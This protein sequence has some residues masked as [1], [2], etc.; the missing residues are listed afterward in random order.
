M[1]KR[2]RGR[3]DSFLESAWQNNGGLEGIPYFPL[4]LL[5]WL[6]ALLCHLRFSLY[7]LG[8]LPQKKA[9]CPVVSVGNLTVGG[10]GKTPVTLYLAEQWQ[11]RGL[12]VGIVSRGY[13]RNKKEALVLVSAGHGPLESPADVGDEPY[14]MAR[15]LK[16]IPIVVAS[17][18]HSGCERITSDFKLDLILLDD[19]FQHLRLKRDLNILLLDA[20]RPFGNKFLL[21]RGPLREPLKEIQ[22]ADLVIFTRV[23]PSSDL[24]SITTK[25]EAQGKPVL[26]SHFKATGLRQV[27]TGR[28]A[29]L[30]DLQ[31][32]SILPFCGIANPEA[33]F[34]QLTALGATIKD[35]VVFE[36]HHTYHDTDFR[37]IGQ[38]AEACGAEWV[39]TTEKDVVKVESLMP[40]INNYWVLQIGLVPE[41]KMEAWENHLLKLEGLVARQN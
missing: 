20:R 6:Y 8:L 40:E 2:G 37:K 15:R 10:T 36:D 27:L 25:I 28:E 3:H 41:G 30:S 12:S 35:V 29:L 26:F 1:K 32:R 18:R 39:I 31:G 14:L 5:S 22:R 11:K 9:A 17:D 23:E 7:A 24:K 21:P 19:G 4:T 34:R 16:G 13:Q 33:F 38:S